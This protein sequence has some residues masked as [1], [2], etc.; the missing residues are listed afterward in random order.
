MTRLPAHGIRP[1]NIQ[2]PRPV[3]SLILLVWHDSSGKTEAV[4]N[5]TKMPSR[6]LKKS[7]HAGFEMGLPCETRATRPEKQ[8]AYASNS[9]ISTSTKDQNLLLVATPRKSKD[10]RHVS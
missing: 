6:S 10:F 1:R 7:T 8:S 5:V 9:K 2:A 4:K 3:A